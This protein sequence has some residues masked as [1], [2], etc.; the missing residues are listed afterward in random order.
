MA[1]NL[2]PCIRHELGKLVKK[3]TV[4]VYPVKG[5]AAPPKIEEKFNN[6]FNL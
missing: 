3:G 2:R 6:A 1:K 5:A 4:M